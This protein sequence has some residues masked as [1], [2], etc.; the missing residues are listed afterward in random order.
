MLDEWV[1]IALL[2]LLL[3]LQ[4][5]IEEYME[6]IEQIGT[7]MLFVYIA[8]AILLYL[9]SILNLWTLYKRVNY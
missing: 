6:S 9:A 5:A 7:I 3:E 2:N 8:T 4:S 1:E